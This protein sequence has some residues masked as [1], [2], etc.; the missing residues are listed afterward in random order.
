MA[1]DDQF[2]VVWIDH[3]REP[4]CAPNPEYPD[5]IDVTAPEGIAPVCTVA[6]PYPAKRCGMY[7]VK[8]K[9]CGCRVIITTAGRPDDP[10]SVQIP[11]RPTAGTA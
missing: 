5:G 10:R 3:H 11:C 1:S 7:V 8:C 4:Q 6:L 2:A 9:M